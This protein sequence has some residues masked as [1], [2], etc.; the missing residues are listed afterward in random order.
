MVTIGNYSG[1]KI[2]EPAPEIIPESKIQVDKSILANREFLA[3][4]RPD[5]QN[6]KAITGSFIYA[7]APDYV[8]NYTLNWNERNWE[9]AFDQ[10]KE[11]NIDTVIFQASIWNELQE[12]YYKSQK[13]S[14]FHCWDVVEPMLNAAKEKNLTVFL[15]GYGSISGWNLNLNDNDVMEEIKHQTDCFCELLRYKDLF[16]GIYY[17]P[18]TA[19]RGIRDFQREQRLHWIYQTYFRKI[20]EMTPDKKILI[21]P[22]SKWFPGK[23]EDFIASWLTL[24]NDV[25][26]DIL[27]PQDSIGC[28]G[29]KLQDMA[30]MWKLWRKVADSANLSLWANIELFE[31]LDF[32]GAAPFKTADHKR[33]IQQC[34]EVA[35][36]VEKCICWE[37]LY[38][39]LPD[40]STQD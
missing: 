38:F 2:F 27:A 34:C 17:S 15:G 3:D 6:A 32:G 8:G 11:K 30:D 39:D 23:E 36:Y 40:F 24:L 13:F 22:A 9:L 29:C 37:A 35:P 31:R 33:I 25:P 1:F 19:F 16:D 10:L 4:L 12:V 7:H 18:E 20:K 21:S 5:K 14:S 28:S 26:L